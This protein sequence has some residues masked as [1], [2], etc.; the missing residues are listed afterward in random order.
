MTGRKLLDQFS[1]HSAFD[2][3]RSF[4]EGIDVWPTEHVYLF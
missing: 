4:V 2:C 3:C 1:D